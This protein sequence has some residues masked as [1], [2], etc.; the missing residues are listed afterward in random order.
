M[1]MEWLDAFR[2]H[3]LALPNLAKFAVLLAL[4]AGV[5]ELARRLR[6][7]EL[8]GLVVI[9]LLLG[10]HV[11][12]LYGVN[13][14]IVQFF[15]DLGRLMLMFAVGLEIDI[16]LFRKVRTRSIT[17]GVITTIMPQAL[18]TAFGLAFGYGIIPAIVIGSLLA[19][20]TLI[21][22]PIVTRLGALGFE[23]VVVTIGAT[24]VSDTLSLIIF[25]ICVST[26]TTGFSPS[27]LA[28]QIAEVAIFVPLIVI[29]VSRVGAWILNKLRNNQAGYFITMLG[30]MVVAGVLADSINLPDIVGAFLAGWAVNAAATSHPAKEK[31]VFFG[32]A[33]FIPIFFIVTG[34]LIVPVAVGHT[35]LN[36]FW[37]VAGMI[38]SLILGKGIAAAIAGHAFG[39]ARQARLTMW[40]LT[41]P[42]V[43]A[44]LAAT[45]V[46]YDTLNA[47]GE[48]LLA[49]EI[50]NTVLVLLV[51]T[52]LL[53]PILTE[54]F[55]PGMV[56][57]EAPTTPASA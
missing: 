53:G 2:S 39:Y 51:V 50:F 3:A 8:V 43:A 29:G 23:P 20:H 55:T 5:P 40:A 28:V 34:F 26:Y 16:S 31:L 22:L 54:L 10:P 36:S 32:K 21:S 45:L 47:A 6:I 41:L 46:G 30:I 44:T 35:I 38:G 24:M 7:P 17:F 37:L 27:G 19:S 42:Q 48:R 4:I 18:G 57:Q 25:G 9:G 12:G 1:T 11:L 49:D 56:R 13:H 14:P 15:A 52:S 33:L